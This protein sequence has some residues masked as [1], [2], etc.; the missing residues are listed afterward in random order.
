MMIPGGDHFR[1]VVISC[2]FRRF[3][4]GWL[5]QE[6][7]VWACLVFEILDFTCLYEHYEARA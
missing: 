3:S 1:N 5:N 6:F 2:G 4:E 7:W